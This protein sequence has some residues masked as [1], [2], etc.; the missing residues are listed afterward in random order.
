MRPSW[1][2]FQINF[3]Q[4][5]KDHRQVVSTIRDGCATIMVVGTKI[6][7]TFLSR[8]PVRTA[9]ERLLQPCERLVYDLFSVGVLPYRTHSTTGPRRSEVP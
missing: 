4:T 3:D 7:S 5:E 8:R 2:S 9:V 6:A 1:Y